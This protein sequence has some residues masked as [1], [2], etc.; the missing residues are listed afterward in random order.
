ME[1]L[2]EILRD[3]TLPPDY[4]DQVRG[5]LVTA[6]GKDANASDEV[7]NLLVEIMGHDKT[8]ASLDLNRLRLAQL[9]DKA[10]RGD[11]ARQ[12]LELARPELITE[13]RDLTACWPLYLKYD[14]IDRAQAAIIRL[15]ALEPSN[16]SHW[17]KRLS[18]QARLG[19]ETAFRDTIRQLL[20]G[21]KGVKLSD[22][23]L[24]QLR[25]HL[26]VSYWRG[27]VRR[28][29][30]E[31]EQDAES[32]A[33]SLDD[34]QA[35]ARSRSLEPHEAA[36]VLWARAWLLANLNRNDERDAAIAPMQEAVAQAET[37]RKEA[38]AKKQQEL[39]EQAKSAK[40]AQAKLLGG[41]APVSPA[42]PVPGSL[43]DAPDG[44][45][46]EPTTDADKTPVPPMIRF[47]DGLNLS[48]DSALSL[49]K[50][51]ALRQTTPVVASAG[52]V[53]A[54]VTAWSFQAPAEH[55][56]TQVLP[57]PAGKLA[58]VQDSG[59]DLAAVSLLTGK[60]LWQVSLSKV[61]AAAPKKQAVPQGGGM[62]RYFR[63]GRGNFYSGGAYIQVDDSSGLALQTLPP[64]LVLLEDRLFSWEKDAVVCREAGTGTI[65]W[66]AEFAP[67]ANAMPS[68]PPPMT[69]GDGRV[70]VVF[71]AEKYA[72]ALEPKSGKVLWQAALS[73]SSAADYPMT[74]GISYHN[75]LVLV[76]G[77]VPTLLE[78]ATGRVRW[79]MQ[80]GTEPGFP[81]ELKSAES[82]ESILKP[83]KDKSP[84]WTSPQA[85]QMMSSGQ[86][87]PLYLAYTQLQT[88][89]ISAFMQQGGKIVS[90]ANSWMFSSLNSMPITCTLTPD[91]LVMMDDRS[92]MSFSLRLPMGG[93]A[94][95]VNGTLLG[96]SRDKMAFLD[97]STL[98]LLATGS[99][100]TMSIGLSELGG[101]LPQL[102][103]YEGCVNGSR[104][105]VTGL[106]GVGIWQIH[107]G[108]RIGFLPWPK[109]WEK[110]A[111][112]ISPLPKL[113]AN[114]GNSYYYQQ[115]AQ[116]APGATVN[117]RGS[118]YNRNNPQNGATGMTIAP[119]CWVAGDLLITALSPE[120]IIALRTPDPSP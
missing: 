9:Y 89:P 118:I 33:Q 92:V 90:L 109:E 32:I 31:E 85:S 50:E 83:D 80:E 104:V 38:A 7:Q 16:L 20:A 112:K 44:N 120:L 21:L 22:E 58:V 88:Q 86:T 119:R 19:D 73:G 28:F 66:E 94:Y 78:A 49:L 8:G 82:G 57:H 77:V 29:Q 4:A 40:E 67:K 46:P 51:P 18:L 105:Y 98:N 99:E 87:P 72:A 14:L 11:L 62:G 81:V 111:A 76:Y 117:R 1:S 39:L 69:T 74:K 61:E 34:L 15:T 65:L 63:G 10:Q 56:I 27:I 100:K 55:T 97:N 54:L 116:Y 91:R 26:E 24:N 103:A 43:W 106:K 68:S 53:G 41:T 5:L 75:G 30:K 36:W 102:G 2:K 12:A 95:S 17:E 114:T 42:A 48:L 52:P 96:A 70:Y 25:K 47:P 93:L 79:A 115:N 107:T 37:K 110:E 108:A 13:P 6:L 71:P 113:A 3:K 101:L 84:V 45:G 60:V 23:S 35:I 59:G 64:P